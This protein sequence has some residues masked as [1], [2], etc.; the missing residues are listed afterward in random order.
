[1]CI[2]MHITTVCRV[3]VAVACTLSMSGV[4][5][6]HEHSTHSMQFRTVWRT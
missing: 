3:E 4:L 6:A 2:E 5:A 1:M